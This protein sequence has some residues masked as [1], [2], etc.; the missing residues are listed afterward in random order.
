[1]S[2]SIF[3]DKVTEILHAVFDLPESQTYFSRYLLLKRAARFQP[4]P[5]Q[6]LI[7][8]RDEELMICDQ[9]YKKVTHS[10]LS[11]IKR[12][13]Y[14]S[15]YVIHEIFHFTQNIAGSDSVQKIKA[16]SHDELLKFDLE[17]DH[18]SAYLISKT[19]LADS[20]GWDFMTLKRALLESLYFFPISSRHDELTRQRKTHR[21]LS[22]ALE[23]VIRQESLLSEQ[24][25]LIYLCNHQSWSLNSQGVFLSHLGSGSLSE[26]ASRLMISAANP[27]LSPKLFYDRAQNIADPIAKEFLGVKI[28]DLAS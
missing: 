12:A 9:F 25:Y 26:E 17:A 16:C 1:M 3:E 13:Q 6:S 8:F 18:I 20:L 19:E 22:L 27:A 28:D 4:M 14:L 5:N 24:S 15:L 23:Q 21:V 11:T 10:S 2:R 7:K